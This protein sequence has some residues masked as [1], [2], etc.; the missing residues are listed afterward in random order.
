VTLS[1]LIIACGDEN[2][3]F[4]NLDQCAMT[5]DWSR[6]SGTKITFGTDQTIT[7]GEGTDKLGL[8][9]WLDR[10]VAAK[11]IAYAALAK[12]TDAPRFTAADEGQTSEG[13]G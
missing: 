8:V 7:P 6:K 5:L 4:Q 10:K 2:V 13:G 12:S 11:A 9:V 1:E 3:A